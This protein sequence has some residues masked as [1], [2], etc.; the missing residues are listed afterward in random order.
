MSKHANPFLI[1]AFVLGA[2]VLTVITILLLA[3]GQWFQEPRQHVMYFEG[4]G[5]GLQEGA[6]VV[7]LGVKV[8]TVKRIH[9]GLDQESGVFIVAVTVE[10]QPSMVE[11][12]KQENIDLRDPA[13]ISTL[14]KQ[15]L[16]ARL[17]M[18]SLLT[19]QLYIDL[20]F[21]PEKPARFISHAPDVSEIPTIPTT[22]D[23]LASKLEG[24]PVDKF[25]ADVAI[26]SESI[27]Q[28]LAT[29]EVQELPRHLE[30][31]LIH[32]TSLARKLDSMTP[33]LLNE[34]GVDLRELRKALAS[35]QTVLTKIGTASDRMGAAAEKTGAAATTIRD[36]TRQDSPI[37]ANL[38]GASKELSETARTVRNLTDSESPTIYE[39]RAALKEMTRAAQALRILT[40]T[41]DQQPEAIIRGKR[42][43]KDL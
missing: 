27:K 7:F 26:I 33:S 32:M 2:M 24:F 8:G 40:E 25:F 1:G 30:S 28:I 10:I 13:T 18:Q 12:S 9:L 43:D 23:E 37:V 22:V 19:G 42:A 5:Q 3:G 4:A 38:A 29:P 35:A 11:S 21:H 17:R 41:L 20:D 34:I 39:I 31:T 6:P 15:G 16:R 14:V 36:L